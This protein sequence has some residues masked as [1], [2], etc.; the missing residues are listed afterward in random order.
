MLVAIL[1]WP[2]N[3]QISPT[4]NNSLSVLGGFED[5]ENFIGLYEVPTID[6]NFPNGG[7]I[8]LLFLCF[9]V[10]QDIHEIVN[11]P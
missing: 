11:Q 8:Y 10:N 5:H 4:R 6:A 3:A 2:M 7:A 1:S 9:R